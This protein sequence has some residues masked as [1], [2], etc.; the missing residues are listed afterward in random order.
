MVR[1]L[2]NLSRAR[3]ARHPHFLLPLLGAAADVVAAVAAAN[4]GGVS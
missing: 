4:A 1:P 3:P 2:P